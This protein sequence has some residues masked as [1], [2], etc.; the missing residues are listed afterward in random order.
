MSTIRAATRRFHDAVVV[1]PGI[2]GSE[3]CDHAGRVLWGLS[4]LRWYAS[5]WTT[6]A[7]LRDLAVTDDERS[8]KVGRVVATQL[9]KTPIGVPLLHGVEPYRPLTNE[10]RRFAAA[11]EA[12][13]EFAY[14]WR[15]AVDH[16]ARA[17]EAFATDAL[18][19]WR[20]HAYWHGKD[21]RSA[22]VILVAHSMGGL[23]ARYYVSVL[24]G[25]EIVRQ[26]FTL[27]T[28]VYGAVKAAYMI[29]T[30]A[31]AKLPARRLRDV[32]RTMP[33]VYDLLPRYRCVRDGVDYRKLTADD[34][35]A[36]GG[37]RQLADEAAERSARIL[38]ASGDD[39]H[40]IVGVNQK[41]MQSMVIKN[42]V[43]MVEYQVPSE[44]GGVED[45]RGDGTVYRDATRHGAGP[46][47]FLSQT[48]TGLPG[49]D[50]KAHIV[51]VL[52][53]VNGPPLGG[54]EIGVDIP[55]I[56]EA[57]SAFAVRVLTTDDPNA[58]TISIEDVT[59][60][61]LL[62]DVAVRRNEEGGLIGECALARPGLYR[63]AV[64]GEG[65]GAVT[66]LVLADDPAA[67]G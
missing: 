63:V 35:V 3:L 58:V 65:A 1:V 30:G 27:G 60:G 48:H 32:T 10:L 50:A 29:S 62:P 4:D 19:R 13:F 17:L 66:E 45:A 51:G 15:L 54:A 61:I 18:R 31:E 14:D 56:V 8:G 6:G 16:N 40:A 11:P 41:T 25:S 67:W 52:T 21:S 47:Q 12:V 42:D 43:A 39:V 24:G 46:V 64:K 20:A 28:P 37:D 26:T 55:D 59:N 49:S 44:H 53:D 23:I 38:A 34:V 7:A 5:A 22:R 2:M 9:V 57:G 33:G 36:V